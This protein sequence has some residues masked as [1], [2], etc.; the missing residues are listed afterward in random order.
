MSYAQLKHRLAR[1]EVI[2]LDGATGSELQR[3]GAKI[4]NSSWS[5]PAAITDFDLLTEI[6]AD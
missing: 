5:A 6:H 4:D 2:I 1:D 3:R